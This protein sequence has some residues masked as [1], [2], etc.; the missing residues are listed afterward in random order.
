MVAPFRTGYAVS[1]DGQRFLVNSLLPNSE[2]SPITIL[3]NGM[4]NSRQ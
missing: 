2:P 1:A 4:Q 3:L